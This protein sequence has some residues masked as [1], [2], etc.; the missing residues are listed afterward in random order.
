M[1]LGVAGQV[2]QGRVHR[3]SGLD[4]VVGKQAKGLSEAREC[5]CV[6]PRG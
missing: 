6:E 2:A 5:R 1:E 3:A 4:A